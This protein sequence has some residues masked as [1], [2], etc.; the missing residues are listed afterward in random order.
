MG[1]HWYSYTWFPGLLILIDV[2]IHQSISF[3]LVGKIPWNS[4]KFGGA[5][6]FIKY[7]KGICESIWG[8]GEWP[9]WKLVITNTEAF[10]TLDQVIPSDTIWCD[11]YLSAFH[12]LKIGCLMPVH[13]LL[14]TYHQLKSLNQLQQNYNRNLYVFIEDNALVLYCKCHQ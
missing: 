3:T 2:F 11:G 7:K 10:V 13:E 4:M 8:D 9:N 5:Y 12:R 14:Q 1:Q 6:H